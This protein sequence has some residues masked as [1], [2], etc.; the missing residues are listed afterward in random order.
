MKKP[1][2][3]ALV[4][5]LLGVTSANA[6]EIDFAPLASA[7][8]TYLVVPLL[9]ALATWIVGEAALLLRRVAAR[10]PAYLDQKTSE[11]LAAN[12]N[13]VL[14]KAIAFAAT[15]AHAQI[16]RADPAV[17]RASVDGWIASWAAD[18]AVKHAPDLMKQAGD[19]V[20][21]IV[22]RIGDH[23]AVLEV[24]ALGETAQAAA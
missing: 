4:L 3:V 10:Y 16:G 5:A 15:Q 6:G 21:K 17:F 2:L 13:G 12:V 14:D 22:A 7:A 19:V 11:L 24:K 23:P 8:V 20:E 1:F 18:Y 9:G